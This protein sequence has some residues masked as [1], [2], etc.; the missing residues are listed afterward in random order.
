MTHQ[1]KFQGSK[2]KCS[3]RSWFK[4]KTPF[5]GSNEAPDYVNNKAPPK[6]AQKDTYEGYCSHPLE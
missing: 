3:Q 2:L 5:K 1:L 6:P 4:F